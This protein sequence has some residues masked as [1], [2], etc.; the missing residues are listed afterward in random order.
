[1][2]ELLVASA[3]VRAHPEGVRSD[4]HRARGAG[5]LKLLTPRAAGNAAWIVTSSLGGG[6][7]DGDAVALDVEIDTGA[8]AVVTTQA[9]TKAYKGRAHQELRV[10]A[11]EGANAIVVPDHLVPF[12]NARVVQATRLDLASSASLVLCDILT[13]GRIAHGEVWACERVDLTLSIMR[14]G[15]P[16]LVDRVVLDRAHGSIPERMHGV[17]A[18]ATCVV[19]GPRVAEQA[20]TVL[21]RVAQMPLRGEIVMAASPLDEGVLVRIAGP[22][23]ERVITATRAQLVDACAALGEDPWARKW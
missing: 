4:V 2:S 22:N 11:G 8:T 3:I 5:P 19:L 16:R 18:I 23:I 6:L 13:A 12:A 15:V 21:A 7:V 9:S 17:G 10:R 20:R 14:G 1:M